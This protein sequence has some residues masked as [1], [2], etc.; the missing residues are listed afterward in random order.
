MDIAVPEEVFMPITSSVIC[1]L[2]ALL[3]G[4]LQHVIPAPTDKAGNSLMANGTGPYSAYK[5]IIKLGVPNEPERVLGGFAEV[6]GLRGVHKVGDVTLKRGVVDSLDLWNW[7]NQA[8][9]NGTAAQRNVI[10]ILR[11]EA[12]NPVQTWKLR[13]VV[14]KKFTG[15]NLGGKSGD[16]A[17]EELILSAE[18]I[19]VVHSK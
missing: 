8:R 15:P 9:E 7:L 18:S 14:P 3:T 16:V 6:T 19:V 5:Y 11:D 2:L 12:G 10:I 4:P 13:N 1:L 17:L